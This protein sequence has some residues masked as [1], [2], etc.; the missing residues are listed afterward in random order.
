[1]KRPWYEDGDAPMQYGKKIRIADEKQ[2]VQRCRGFVISF[3]ALIAMLLLITMFVTA[4][5]YF[6]KASFES[7]TRVLLKEVAMDS[8]TALEKS[9][10]LERALAENETSE[11]RAF[12]NQMPYAICTDL[13]IYNST[14]LNNVELVVLRPDCKKNFEDSATVKRSVLVESGDSIELYLAELRAWYRVNE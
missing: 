4:T 8:I 7:N 5:A 1:M 10:K 13:R 2:H 6:G 11:I 12:I 14:D 3:D 9:G